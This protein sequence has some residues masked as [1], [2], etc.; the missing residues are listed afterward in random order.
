M[1]QRLSQS[2]SHRREARR[3]SQHSPYLGLWGRIRFPPQHVNTLT[4]AFFRTFKCYDKIFFLSG[5]FCLCS[6]DNKFHIGK[7]R[8]NSWPPNTL[9]CS[10]RFAKKK[11]LDNV[12]NK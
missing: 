8:V 5:L 12:N 9:F 7:L 6:Q 2:H 11:L 4:G 10:I 3:L 1:E